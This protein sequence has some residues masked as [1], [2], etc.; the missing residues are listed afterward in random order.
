MN[1]KH[2]SFIL[3][4]LV[5]VITTNVVWITQNPWFFLVL[6]L[7]PAVQWLSEN[8]FWKATHRLMV[9][10]NPEDH[11]FEYIEEEVID[12]LSGVS[13]ELRV[14]FVT[15]QPILGSGVYLVDVADAEAKHLSSINNMLS[16]KGLEARIYRLN[17]PSV[18]GSEMQLLTMLQFFEFYVEPS[19]EPLKSIRELQGVFRHYRIREEKEKQLESLFRMGLIRRVDVPGAPVYRIAPCFDDVPL[20]KN[21]RP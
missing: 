21:G 6:L 14:L 5:L 2:L 7:I 18:T 19:Y 16:E 10:Y 20:D 17:P 12:A 8:L 15:F 3:S 13:E 11:E 9:R 4:L 1:R